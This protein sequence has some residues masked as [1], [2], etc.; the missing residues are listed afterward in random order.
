[1]KNPFYISFGAG[2]QSSAM[3]ALA[4]MGII[5]DVKGA[6]FADTG[7]E[8][9]WVYSFLR[10]VKSKSKIPIHICKSYYGSLSKFTLDRKFVSAPVYTN[11]TIEQ[12]G[13]KNRKIRGGMG[14]RQCTTLFKIQPIF[15]KVRELEDIV[16]K[17]LPK[18]HIHLGIGISTDEEGRKKESKTRWVK[19]IYPLLEMGISRNRCKEIVYGFYGEIPKKSSCVFCPYK[20]TKDFRFL[21]LND[22]EG[23]KKA[24]EFDERI[25]ILDKSK[26]V[27]NFIHRDKI[28]LKNV[29]LDE[30]KKQ[31]DFFDSMCEEGGCGL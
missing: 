4:E 8:P 6:I 7:D 14:Q 5:K 18:D 17:R 22:P 30:H 16:R 19:N 11:E 13:M 24:C 12:I 31:I 9:Q 21:K 28:P 20:T 25:R 10:K 23:F 3:L 26:K 29:N 15:N 1:M 27:E 2:V